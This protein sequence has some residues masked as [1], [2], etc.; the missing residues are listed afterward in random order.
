MSPLSTALVSIRP[1]GTDEDTARLIMSWENAIRSDPR[2]MENSFDN[3]ILEWSTHWTWFQNLRFEDCF[4]VQ[5]GDEKV[6]FLNCKVMDDQLKIGVLI[7]IP[8]HGFGYGSKALRIYADYLFQKYP[9]K[10][11]IA[12]ILPH[13]KASFAAFVRAKFTEIA[14]RSDLIVMQYEG[15]E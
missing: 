15:S 14:R 1:I 13:N 7:A 8:F 9:A 6:G 2:F 12:E 10:R 3:S 5:A 4:F 11:I